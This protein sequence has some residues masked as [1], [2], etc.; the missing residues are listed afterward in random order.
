[1]SSSLSSTCF[2]IKRSSKNKI[3]ARSTHAH[4]HRLKIIILINTPS[5][6]HWIVYFVFASFC[7]VLFCLLD[8]LFIYATLCILF[9][10]NSKCCAKGELQQAF[11]TLISSP[12]QFQWIA[13][14]YELHC[15]ACIVTD[16]VNGIRVCVSLCVCINI[17]TVLYFNSLYSK[18]TSDK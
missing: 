3:L 11:S 12:P 10:Q 18:L 15:N 2:Y 8:V 7:F 9:V 16:Q 5:T 1:M 4:V 6:F 14:L 17:W 13:S